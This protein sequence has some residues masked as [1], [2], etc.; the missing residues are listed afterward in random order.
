LRDAI[1][2][3]IIGVISPIAVMN[4][5]KGKEEEKVE[6]PPPPVMIQAEDP[7]VE[8]A[9]QYT[10]LFEQALKKEIIELVDKRFNEV[11]SQPMQKHISDSVDRR[12]TEIYS[13]SLKRDI[14]NEVNRRLSGFTPPSKPEPSPVE[15]W[16]DSPVTKKWVYDY[17][18]EYWTTPDKSSDSYRSP[19]S[20]R[21]GLRKDGAVVWQKVK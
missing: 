12:F 20:V 8:L 17:Q 14:E 21:I 16:L 4:Q 3:G 15:L 1:Y 5:I 13:Q 18:N 2:I 9:K 7:K 6:L 11:F 19:P 10:D